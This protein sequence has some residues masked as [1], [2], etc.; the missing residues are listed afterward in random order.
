MR[1]ADPAVKRP[2]SRTTF[3]AGKLRTKHQPRPCNHG[4]HAGPLVETDRFT[5]AGGMWS[6]MGN[7]AACGSTIHRSQVR[8]SA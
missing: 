7:C 1:H 4:W 6:N 8:V 2:S 3:I 5:A